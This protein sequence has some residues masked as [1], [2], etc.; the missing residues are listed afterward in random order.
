M[1]NIHAAT[2][3]ALAQPVVRLAMMARIE[4]RGGGQFA[5]NT[6]LKPITW[7]GVTYIGAG[8]IG[9]ISQINET[10]DS[11]P[12]NYSIT[13]SALDATLVA[14]LNRADYLNHKVTTWLLV[15]DASHD[16][17]GEPVH[18]WS[19]L[20]DKITISMGRSATVDISVRDRRAI[21]QNPQT[22]LWTDAAQKRRDPTDNGFK[23]VASL[24][25]LEIEWPKGARR[26]L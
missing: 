21:W 2:A 22:Q 9:S 7:Q 16:V 3:T 23:V 24:D 14:G 5:F 26:K 25:G 4:F 19:G 1:R 13:L 10:S 8:A 6:L 18:W 15:L 11:T 20:T 12:G 17:I